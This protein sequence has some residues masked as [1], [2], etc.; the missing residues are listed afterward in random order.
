MV[1]FFSLS[2]TK[3]HY[4]LHSASAL[5]LCDR[6]YRDSRLGRVLIG[7]SNHGFPTSIWYASLSMTDITITIF[8]LLQGYDSGPTDGT[9]NAP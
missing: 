8:A 2:T 6:G 1:L 9:K 3:L 7:P 4:I 5:L